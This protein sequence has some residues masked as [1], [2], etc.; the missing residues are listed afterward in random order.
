MRL[1]EVIERYSDTPIESVHVTLA[2][3]HTHYRA[4]D[5]AIVGSPVDV[6]VGDFVRCNECQTSQKVV[7][8]KFKHQP[9]EKE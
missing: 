1:I 4:N 8:A 7:M 2:C 3:R 9:V 5:T 6:E